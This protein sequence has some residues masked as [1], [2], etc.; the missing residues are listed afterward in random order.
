VD[1]A[2]ELVLERELETGTSGVDRVSPRPSRRERLTTDARRAVGFMVAV[3][4]DAERAGG[5]RRR[6]RVGHRLEDLSERLEA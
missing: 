5:P 3:L 4:V 2:A 6:G 1:S